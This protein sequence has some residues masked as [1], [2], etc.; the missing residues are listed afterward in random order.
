MVGPPYASPPLF[1]FGKI[2]L[3]S[4]EVYRKYNYPLLDF[5]ITVVSINYL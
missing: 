1:L 3:I 5:K 2:I 4:P